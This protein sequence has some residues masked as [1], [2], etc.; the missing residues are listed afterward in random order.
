MIRI[1]AV[2]WI[3]RAEKFFLY[4]KDYS[5]RKHRTG[6]ASAALMACQLTVTRVIPIAPK[7][8]PANIHH[9]IPA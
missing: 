4:K 8:A 1:S 5:E 3:I 7:A 6:L 2:G 9:D